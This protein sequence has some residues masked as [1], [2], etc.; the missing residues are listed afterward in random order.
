MVLTLD[1]RT[2]D[3]IPFNRFR[4][5]IKALKRAAIP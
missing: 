5:D 4:A 1:I 3:P 2:H